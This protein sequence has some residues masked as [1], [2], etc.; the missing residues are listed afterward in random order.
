MLGSHVTTIAYPL[1]VLRLTGSPFE[2]GWVAFAATAPSIL[3]HMPARAL[4]D[5]WDPRQAMLMSEIDR[6]IAIAAVAITLA[7]GESSVPLLIA[8]AVI[9]GVLEVFSTLAERRYVGSLV[10]REQVS[11][12]LTRIE[13]RTHVMLLAGRP[14][15]GL[16]FG[17]RP[18]LPFLARISAP[19]P[20]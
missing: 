17:I 18:I 20:G 8:A 5:R 16:L 9:E 10:G 6:G 14:P 12:A 11:P 1:L 3:V 13:A 4:V 7:L 2:A 15:G 19:L